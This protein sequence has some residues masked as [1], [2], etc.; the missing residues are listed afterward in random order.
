MPPEQIK[1][2]LEEEVAME[3]H[4]FVSEVLSKLCNNEQN[5]NSRDVSIFP[6]LLSSFP[7][8]PLG[9]FV[10]SALTTTTSML[11]KFPKSVA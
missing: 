6:R 1:E 3:S 10:P 7:L 5:L 4:Y 9:T 8:S 2:I 11:A